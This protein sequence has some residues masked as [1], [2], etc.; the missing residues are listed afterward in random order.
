MSDKPLSASE[1][2]NQPRWLLALAVLLILGGTVYAALG[3]GGFSI[4]ALLRHRAAI[5]AFVAEHRLVAVLAYIVLY[6]AVVALS[7]PGAALLTVSGGFLFGLA[8]GAV[9]AVIGATVGATLVFLL[10]RTALGEPLLRRAGPRALKLAQGFREDAFSYLL[11]L[12][13]V[14]AFPFFLVNLVPAFAGVR[15][16]PFVAATALGVIPGAFVYAFA[17]SGLDSVLAAKSARDILTPELIG[18][19]VALALLAL[20]PVLVKRWRARSRATE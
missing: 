15:L 3:P 10:A 11:F 20:L 1:L 18:A 16:A 19:L 17:G 2:R 4:E 6:I 8:V 14:P 7:V 5:D 12:R 9:A 13:L